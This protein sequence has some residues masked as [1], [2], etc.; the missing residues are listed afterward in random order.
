MPRRSVIPDPFRFAAEGG[1][2][3]GAIAL[4]DLGRLS[5]VLVDTSGEVTYS[6]V[7]EFGLD[8]KALLRLT[9]AGMLPMHCQR[10]L[11]RL[12]W[13]LDV[14]VVLELVRPG[15]PIPEDELENDEFDAIEA[16]PDL[17]VLALV[18]DEIVLAVPIAPRHESCD[19]PRPVKG[20]E[21]ESP[22]ASLVK[23]RKNDGAE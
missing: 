10:C 14:E 19:A 6:L 9:A 11:G 8:R 5:D 22:F 21:K 16:V 15:Q 13:P 4:A 20:S 17:D 23:L 2:V 12:E 1:S 7:G 18:E 3:S